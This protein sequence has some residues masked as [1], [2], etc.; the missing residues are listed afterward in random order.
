[1]TDPASRWPDELLDRMRYAADPLAD[2]AVARIAGAWQALPQDATRAQMEAAHGAQWERLAAASR[3]FAG[4]Q[5]NASLAGWPAADPAAPDVAAALAAFVGAAR[6]LPPWVDAAKIERAEELFVDHG[7]LSCILLFCASL[8]ECYVIP[9]LSVVLNASGQLEQ[10]T[11]YRIRMTAA[12]IFPV[13]MRG[14]L[15]RPDG[16]GVAQVLKVRLIHATIRSLILHETPEEA[17]AALG[18]L[19]KVKGAGVV[20]PHASIAASRSMSEAMFGHGWKLGEDGLPCNQEE[21][22]YTLLTFGYVF[23]R[24]LRRLGI[25]LPGVDEEAFLHCWNVAGHVLGIERDLMADTMEE[26]EALFTRMQA[27]GRA[28]PVAADPRPALGRALVATMRHSIPLALVKPFPALMLRYLCGARTAKDL[29]LRGPA[30]TAGS[31]LFSVT[32][33]AAR[34]L[35]RVVRLFVADFSIARFVTRVVGYRLLTHVLMDQTR[36]LSLPDHLLGQIGSMTA[37]WGDDP[38]APHWMNRLEDRLTTAGAWGV[39]GDSRPGPGGA[40]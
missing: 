28:R 36:P 39:G 24:C 32:L 2:A 5:T 31:A 27:R 30:A 37:G 15:T 13:M 7:A 22:A 14:G 40:P 38:K 33:F 12:M 34:V 17:V 11:D 9:D 8:P 6:A 29:G 23:L 4:L 35:D 19:R 1:M 10:R 21:L 25:G 3:L 20:A 18:A 26:S 16:A